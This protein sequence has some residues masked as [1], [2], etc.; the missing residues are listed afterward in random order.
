MACKALPST[1]KSVTP[2]LDINYID[3]ADLLAPVTPRCCI[4]KY[5]IL[6]MLFFLTFVTT[7]KSL[8]VLA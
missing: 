5:S 3:S 4:A 6:Y 7:E 1:E 2:D 8:Q